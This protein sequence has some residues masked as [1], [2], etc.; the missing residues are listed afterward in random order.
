[1]D[2][3]LSRLAWS[4]Q[5]VI[6]G[7]IAGGV[8]LTL[9]AATAPP[10]ATNDGGDLLSVTAVSPSGAWAAGFNSAGNA[11]LLH[12]NGSS[13]ARTAVPGKTD[14]LNGV[15]AD[16]ASDAWAVGAARVG[17]G[18]VNLALHWNGTRWAKV[19]VPSPGAPPIADV[20]SGVSADSPDDAWA[21]GSVNGGGQD[22]DL[23]L[24]W[25]GTAWTR[26][27]IRQARDN[28][29]AVTALSPSDVWAVGGFTDPKGGGGV[30]VLHWNGTSWA[31]IATPRIGGSLDAVTA[32]SPRDA[33][34]VGSCC[35]SFG[36]GKTVVLHWNGTA[37]TRQAS[38][39]PSTKAAVPINELNGVSGL[40]ATNAWAVGDYGHVA[41]GGRLALFKPL[42]LHWNG[43]SW[44]KV[45]SPFFGPASAL[46]S[47]AALSPTDAW[48]VGG[49][50]P[51]NGPATTLI[52]HWN[53]T[54]WTR[55]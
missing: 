26:V 38:P 2:T 10:P 7:L 1:M 16:S 53:G 44:T 6:S 52:L 51:A 22:G 32:V 12:W 33:W 49:L 20:L 21:I 24:H 23:V 40:S 14:T 25:N 15:S 48:A 31:R 50:S 45:A 37:W 34:A 35:G 18:A 3:G 8:A 55:A 19:A 46:N 36:T 17:G 39:N 9:A 28:L 54:A 29:L 42:V 47:V 43:V 4:R 13:W 5:A 27:P 30:L 11:L 41:Q